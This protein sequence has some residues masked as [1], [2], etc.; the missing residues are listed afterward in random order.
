LATKYKD[1]YLN[2]PFEVSRCSYKLL[3]SSIFTAHAD[4]VRRQ[5]IYGLLQEDDP[6]T[7]HLIVSFLLFDGRQHEESFRMMNEEGSFPRLLELLQVYKI[8]DGENQAALHR[9][10]MDLLYEMSRI[11]R[12]RIEDLGGCSRWLRRLEES[13]NGQRIL[14]SACRR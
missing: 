2:S 3:A 13:A 1:E 12:I 10:L 14:G 11:Q 7:L 5:M 4:Y 9:M 8:K 6:D